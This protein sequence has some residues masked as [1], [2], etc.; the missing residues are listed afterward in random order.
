V[1]VL[2]EGA[3]PTREQ[4]ELLKRGLLVVLGQALGRLQHGGGGRVPA[5][6]RGDRQTVRADRLDLGDRVQRAPLVELDIDQHERL[7]PGPEPGHGLAHP[8]GHRPDL[9]ALAGEQRDDPVGLAQLLGSQDDGLVAIDDR[10]GTDSPS[11]RV[12]ARLGRNV[13]TAPEFLPSAVPRER[14]YLET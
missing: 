3:Q 12:N 2:R 8:L 4:E 10:H 9:A 1:P 6:V 14:P 5:V 11:Y 13:R 7:Q